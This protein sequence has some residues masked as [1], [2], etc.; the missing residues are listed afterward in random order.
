MPPKRFFKKRN[1]DETSNASTGGS[2]TSFTNTVEQSQI[3]F[4]LGV[5]K[6]KVTVRKF[7]NMKLIDLREYYQKDGKWL[8]GSKGLSLT[9]EQ[10]NVLVSKMVDIGEALTKI[11]DSHEFNMMKAALNLKDQK[12]K[13]NSTKDD[14]NNELLASAAANVVANA[15]AEE[16]ADDDQDEDED[17]GD[18]EFEDVSEAA[19]PAKKPKKEDD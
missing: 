17:F 11:D 3:Q 19:P 8:P 14:Q 9:E 12:L 16:E 18:I 15:T 1:Y 13:E 5:E 2:G 7:K 10:W 4:D 6:K